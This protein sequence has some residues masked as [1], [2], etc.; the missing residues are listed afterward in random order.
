MVLALALAVAPS[1]VPRVPRPSVDRAHRVDRA[2]RARRVPR[3]RASRVAR[4]RVRAV[5]LAERH[6]SVEPKSHSRAALVDIHTPGCFS[7]RVSGETLFNLL[8]HSSLKPHIRPFLRSTTKKP[9]RTA[10]D[11]SI[12]IAVSASRTSRTTRSRVAR[13]DARDGRR[14]TV[15]DGRR[16]IATR[17]DATPATTTRDDDDDDARRER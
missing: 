1:V 15:V 9:T 17:R 6:I 11:R 13:R 10:A 16:R 4:R 14:A 7:D 3:R 5:C 12:Q 2:S 8:H